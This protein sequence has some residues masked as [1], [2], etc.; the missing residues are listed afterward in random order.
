MSGN[1]TRFYED[2]FSPEIRP[3]PDGTVVVVHPDQKYLV[4][5][6]PP[7][8][9]SLDYPEAGRDLDAMLRYAREANQLQTASIGIGCGLLITAIL[10]VGLSL[11]SIWAVEA[12][13]RSGRR[14]LSRLICY[15]ELY[16]STSPANVRGIPVPRVVRVCLHVPRC[17]RTALGVTPWV[18][19]PSWPG[20]SRR[21]MLAW[22]V[23][24]IR[25]LGSEYM[26]FGPDCSPCC[27]G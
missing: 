17:R 23:V 8:K 16:F 4:R 5:F 14:L 20:L 2:V 21:P 3:R 24:G 7:E 15:A 26:C 9:Q 6:L 13:A 10:F 11:T 27:C 12:P 25:W 18:W 1:F 22:L 19:R